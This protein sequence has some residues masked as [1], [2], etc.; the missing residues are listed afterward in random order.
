MTR[1]KKART[2]KDI[3]NDPR[4]ES[5]SDERN[6]WNNDGIWI[7]LKSPYWDSC[8]ETSAVH[9]FSVAECLEVFNHYVEQN[10]NYWKTM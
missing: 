7:Y 4:D 2:L 8:S 9:E 3:K 5:I 6:G 1:F 10:P